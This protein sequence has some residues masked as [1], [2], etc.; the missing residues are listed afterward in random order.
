MIG[1]FF[2]FHGAGFTLPNSL[3]LLMSPLLRFSSFIDLVNERIG[4]ASSWLILL[5]V[6]ICTVNALVRYSVNLSSNGWLEVQWYLNSAMFLLVAAYALKRNNHVRIDVIAG[7]LS[8]RAQAWIDIL[9]SLF[10]LLPVSLIII[11]YSWP[12]LVNSWDLGE[13]SS[14]PGGLI[15]WPVRLLIPVAFSMP[16]LQGV[17]ELIKR[18]AFLKG[19]IPNPAEHPKEIV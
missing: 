8:P 17:S 12:S 1:M 13:H 9:G 3:E 14:D 4:K 10:A 7:R 6:V 11:W 16:A 15:R 2:A 18:V 19:L 5:A